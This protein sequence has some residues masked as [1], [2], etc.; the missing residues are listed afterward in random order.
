MKMMMS[1]AMVFAL[2]A[3]AC[4]QEKIEKINPNC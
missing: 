2:I 1:F 3:M 4:A